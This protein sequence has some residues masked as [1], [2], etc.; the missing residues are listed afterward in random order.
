MVNVWLSEKLIFV[1]CADFERGSATWYRNNFHLCW[2]FLSLEREQ[3]HFEVWFI[4][5]VL[6]CHS[7]VQIHQRRPIPEWAA[8]SWEQCP[9]LWCSKSLESSSLNANKT[10]TAERQW[11]QLR[12]SGGLLSLPRCPPYRFNNAQ[13][14]RSS[15]SHLSR[16]VSALMMIQ[17]APSCTLVFLQRL[18]NCPQMPSISLY[19]VPIERLLLFEVE[20]DQA[21]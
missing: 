1:I 14:S 11:L 21:M 20:C 4:C 7:T 18:F 13:P 16:T 6:Q 3:S 10:R 15:V 2:T 5:A 17:L 8:H 19:A 12:Y 9:L